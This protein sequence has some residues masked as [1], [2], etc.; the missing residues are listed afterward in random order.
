VVIVDDDPGVLNV[1]GNLLTALGHGVVPFSSASAALDYLA[2]M[3]TGVDLIITDFRM[4]DIDGGELLRRIRAMGLSMPAILIS[5]YPEEAHDADSLTALHT[6]I[7]CK[8]VRIKTLA[9][10][11]SELTSPE[12]KRES[13]NRTPLTNNRRLAFN[14]P[15]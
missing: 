3:G 14:R 15:C 1:H 6:S 12:R 11:I 13:D 7:M 2:N 9:A 5:G 10:K 4:P 8:P